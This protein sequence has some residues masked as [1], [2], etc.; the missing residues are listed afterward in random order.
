MKESLFNNDFHK[1]FN[2][3]EAEEMPTV[4]K[5]M[6]AIMMQDIMNRE[7]GKVAPDTIG[8]D[9]YF[10]EDFMTSDMELDFA[11]IEQ[12]FLHHCSGRL[13][14]FN[15][16]GWYGE[17]ER[18]KSAPDFAIKQRMLRLMYNG[19]KLGDAY[20]LELIKYLYKLYYK[21][22]Y[23]QLKR[24]RR[25]T[26]GEILSLVEDEAGCNYGDI[27]RILGMCRFMKIELD[28]R[29]S[30]LFL[31]LDKRRIE[32]IREN[33]KEKEYLA[34]EE[35]LFEDCVRQVDLWTQQ[36]MNE[37]IRTLRKK[38]RIYFDGE[39][40]VEACLR[41]LDCPGDYMYM[42]MTNYFGLGNQLAR[43]LAVLRTMNPNREYSFEEVQRYTILY[44]A[45]SSFVDALDSYDMQIG[46]LTG[47]EPD[48][49]DK[50][51]AIFQAE[52]IPIRQPERKK[53]EEP[54]AIMNVA[55]VSM[56]VAGEG[57][58]LKEIAAL[59]S[60][61]NEQEQKIKDLREQCHQLKASQAE[62]EKL[63]SNYQADREELIALREYAYRSQLEEPPI[64]E[65]SLEEMEK[66][67]ADKN[68]VIIGGHVN[69]LNKLKKRFPNWMFILTEN[70]KTV[71]GK[72]LDG[73]DRVY[74]FTDHL[75]HVTYGK[76]IAVVRERKIPFGYLGSLNIEKM[77]RQIYEDTNL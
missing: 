8:A 46:Y 74:F 43:T 29:C 1:D 41:H 15:D 71:D 49:F 52:N 24:F 32:W 57:D 62:N 25:I 23:N 6:I 18:W 66:A 11:V 58:Y 37:D 7:K 76:F 53:P 10:L 22:E 64:T 20:C 59:R 69:W 21:K 28:E 60:K 26:A 3:T 50:E 72:M 35:G 12:D 39:D 61:V 13:K 9:Y 47:D 30:L 63:L 14:E 77:I 17:D 45:V 68:I 70:Y 51:E 55:P 27:G 36:G 34:F 40:F 54:K 73:K 31:L 38:N 42:C 48:D 2:I 67:I 65:E 4:S 5:D 16:A 19:A 56:G 44:T 75:S 33:E